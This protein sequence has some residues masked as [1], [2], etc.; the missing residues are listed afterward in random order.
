M[1]TTCHTIKS[2]AVIWL[3]ALFFGFVAGPASAQILISF[4]TARLVFQRDRSTSGL[5]SVAGDCQNTTVNQV[6]VRTLQNDSDAI[7]SDW[8]VLDSSPVSGQ[9]AGQVRVP[10]G[11]FRVQVRGLK[12]GAEVTTGTIGPI[13]VGE[14]FVVAGQSNGQGQF[15]HGA[16]AATDSRVSFVPH[17]NLSDTISLPVPPMPQAIPAEGVAGPRGQSTWCWGRLGDRLANR[18]G[19]PILLYNVAWNGTSMRVWQQSILAD[20]VATSYNEYFRPGFP[21]AGLR[22]V[23]QDYVPKTGLR[24]VFWLQGEEEP[25]DTDPNATQYASRLQTVIAQSRQDVRQST[26]AWLVSRTSINNNLLAT[27]ITHYDPVIQAQNAVI[28]NTPNVWPGPDTDVIQIPRPDGVHFS[29]DGLTQLGDAWN[30]Y[31]TDVFFANSVP[32]APT[33]VQLADLRLRLLVSRREGL[34]GNPVTLTLVVQ[35]RSARP[36]TNVRLRLQLPNNLSL[37]N[38]GG[39]TYKRGVLL[40]TVPQVNA[41]SNVLLSAVVQPQQ[42]GLFRIGAEVVRIDQTDPTSRPN[43]A[44][45]D[46][47]DDMAWADFRTRQFG[48]TTFSSPVSANAVALPAVQSNNPVPSASVADLS[49]SIVASQDVVKSGQAVSMSI[50]VTNRGGAAAQNV[51]V[52]C[53]VPAGFYFSSGPNLT[54]SGSFVNGSVGNIPAGSQATFSAVFQV[55]GTANGV[56]QTQIVAASP[57]DPDST[58]NNGYTNGEDDTAQVLIRVR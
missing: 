49:V 20:S 55:L 50:V 35:N 16:K 57:S 24:A 22:R 39:F 2:Q 25:Y 9:F 4:P 23:L 38:A 32:V 29:G 5:V 44:I 26:L 14:V 46:G 54:A 58:P 37:A 7:I 11:W 28:A 41:S 56:F 18:L 31:L 21:Y 47:Q 45:A 34:V 12:D 27:G 52:A 36:A 19:M 13:G 33:S 30:Q 53:Q 10:T 42:A 40:A 15:D 51:Q 43:T 3:F 8:Q 17:F 48:S 6:Q 1:D